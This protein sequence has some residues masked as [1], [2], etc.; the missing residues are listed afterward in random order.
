MSFQG[1]AGSRSSHLSWYAR[2]TMKPLRA[3]LAVPFVLFIGAC[4]VEEVRG[5]PRPPNGS[6]VPPPPGPVAAGPRPAPPP[7]P[8]WHPA[9]PPPPQPVPR[10][11]GRII[12]PIPL[13]NQNTG[14]LDIA[15]LK[16]KIKP[17]RKCGPHEST[18]G[19][20]IHIDCNK[21]R[22]VAQAKPPS[23]RKLKLMF[24][25]KLQLDEPVRGGALPDAVD[26]RTSGTEGPIKDQGQVG[27]CTS[28]SLSSAMDNAIRRQQQSDTTSSIHIWSHYGTPDMG[29][30]GDGNV[31][32]EIA[33]W[34]QWPY[35]ERLACEIDTSGDCGPYTPPVGN[36]STDAQLQAKI[37]QADAEGHWVI[38]EYDQIGSD[39]DTFAAMLATGADVWFAIQVGDSWMSPNGDTIADWDSNSIDGGHAVLF[40]GYRHVNGKRQF[41]VHNSWGTGWADNGFAYIS[42]AMVT[43]FLEGAYKVVVTGGSNPPQPGPTPPGP[44]P[45]GPHKLP[46]IP[47]GPPN[48][49]PPPTPT[50]PPGPTP[51]PTP[52]PG[53]LTDD[54]CGED[55]LVDSV[56][57]QCATICPDD[58]RPA[59]GQCDVTGGVRTPAPTPVPGKPPTQPKP[60]P[61]KLPPL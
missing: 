6:Y 56:T 4:E 55:Q 12:H 57:G 30:A 9:P 41:L 3:A 37:K 49:T 34:P 17:G 44:T 61:R 15:A 5:P 31:G 48:P 50:A 60:A 11:P 36:A 2:A 39:P 52:G 25:G 40:A 13:N 32:K 14:T 16:L 54:D 33:L 18:P 51:P 38:K 47:F 53:Q 22:A 7:P 23:T 42:E 8:A 35:D 58:S 24:A 21:Y 43:G 45:P 27:S 28:F 20:W 46:P 1:S 29:A 59:N 10:F 19:H 26:H